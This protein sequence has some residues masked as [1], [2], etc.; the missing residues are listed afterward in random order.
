M[1]LTLQQ[2]LQRAQHQQAEQAAIN[3]T[4]NSLHAF[5]FLVHYAHL[6]QTRAVEQRQ[7]FLADE[8]ERGRALLVDMVRRLGEQEALVRRLEQEVGELSDDVLMQRERWTQL[9]EEVELQKEVV[10]QGMA[11]YE[12]RMAAQEE[13]LLAQQERLERL[14]LVRF[15]LDAAVDASILAFAFYLARLGVLRLLFRGVASRA[16]PWS[17]PG[18][19]SKRTALVGVGQ[20]LVFALLVERARTWAVENGVHHTVG[21]Y[22]A[23]GQWLLTTAQAALHR[24]A[25]DK[26]SAEQPSDIA[27]SVTVG[28]RKSEGELKAAADTALVPSP[29]PMDVNG[30]VAESSGGVVL[31]AAGDAMSRMLSSVGQAV[32]EAGRLV[33]SMLSFGDPEADFRK[34]FG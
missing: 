19:R 18:A 7:R 20:L 14:L 24:A 4:N 12:E 29:S 16:V 30:G 13:Q 21:S 23:Y 11:R 27:L 1:S 32:T 26:K 17:V 9:H 10:R 3:A 28:E 31:S 5:S 2:L 34:R 25:T 8:V 15:R 22:T 6:S 33:G